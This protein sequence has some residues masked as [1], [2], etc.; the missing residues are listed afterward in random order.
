M[1]II[2]FK[3]RKQY[4]FPRCDAG[5]NYRLRLFYLKKIKSIF[6]VFKV[7]QGKPYVKKIFIPYFNFITRIICSLRY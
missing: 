4:I 7:F 3:A 1:Q 2:Q 5:Q 6:N